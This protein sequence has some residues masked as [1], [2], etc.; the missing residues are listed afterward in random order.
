MHS[1]QPGPLAISERD[2][3]IIEAARTKLSGGRIDFT[4]AA[5]ALREAVEEH[6]RGGRVFMLGATARGPV[7]GSVISGI[8]IA[9]G[10]RG[11]VLIVRLQQGGPLT[12][13]GS[14]AR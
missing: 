12:A 5:R 3:S 9:S 13:L 8:G 7:L 10:A 1:A 11:G 14:F 6:I 2:R 4:E